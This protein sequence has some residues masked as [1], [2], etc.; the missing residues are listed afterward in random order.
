MNNLEEMHFYDHHP[1]Q[2]LSSKISQSLEILENSVLFI[3]S[4][5]KFFLSIIVIIFCFNHVKERSIRLVLLLLCVRQIFPKC[6][7]LW[8]LFSHGVPFLATAYSFLYLVFASI[9]F[10][11]IEIQKHLRLTTMYQIK[12]D[13]YFINK[14]VF[15]L[16][17]SLII[18]IK[19]R[20]H[21]Q[22]W[23]RLCYSWSLYLTF[24]I[25]LKETHNSCKIWTLG[26][27][28]L[29]DILKYYRKLVNILFRLITFRYI[30][31]T[32][33]S[34]RQGNV[35]VV[36]IFEIFEEMRHMKHMKRL[37]MSSA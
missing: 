9:I 12:S 33:I 32:G 29:A 6:T 30:R 24:V 25:N 18:I 10:F 31:R 11:T 17:I 2:L 4:S 5:L 26:L 27:N 20:F 15:F 7:H 36:S 35:L 14:C 28:F 22:L 1:W 3:G 21:L 19:H 23:L 13:N 37:F 8:P 34:S 16:L